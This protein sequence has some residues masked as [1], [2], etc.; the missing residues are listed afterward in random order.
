MV[1][2]SEEIYQEL[3]SISFNCCSPHSLQLLADEEKSLADNQHPVPEEINTKVEEEDIE[4]IE[5]KTLQSV[6]DVELETSSPST[7]IT[8]NAIGSLQ[9]RKYWILLLCLI[10]FK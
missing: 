6:D 8:N 7:T 1:C 9:R 10:F 5:V 3:N 2:C 4:V